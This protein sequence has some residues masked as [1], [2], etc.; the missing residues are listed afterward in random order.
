M[1]LAVLRL[2][3]IPAL[4]PFSA[5]TP[6]T[7][8]V[9]PPPPRELRAVDDVVLTARMADGSRAPS[10]IVLPTLENGRAVFEFMREHFPDTTKLASPTVMPVAWVYID[11]TGVTH[12]PQLIVGSGALAFDS[13]ALAMVERARFAPASVDRRTVPVWV[14]LPVQLGRGALARP[15]GTPTDPDAPHF[16]PYTV[17]PVLINRNVVQRALVREYPRE[18]SSV[19]VGGI[20][21]VWVQ[22][23]EQGAVTRALVKQTSSSAPLDAAALRVARIM[24]FTPAEKQGRKTAV[25]ISLPI[26]FQTK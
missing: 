4:L 7:L 15:N 9:P 22:I 26:V 6:P 25:W 24:R 1:L 3:A 5:D 23:D 8:R 17:K 10:T 18:L 20:V 12:L 2:V 13:L 19:G 14:M 16:T 21:Q 11:E